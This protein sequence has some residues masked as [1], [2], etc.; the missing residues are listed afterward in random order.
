MLY[1]VWFALGIV[2][3]IYITSIRFRIRINRTFNRFVVWIKNVVERNKK[4]HEL[5]DEIKGL[6]GTGLSRRVKWR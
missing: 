2:M 4:I 3:G 6:K 5:E 1:A